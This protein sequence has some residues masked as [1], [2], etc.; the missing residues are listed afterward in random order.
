[1]L[2]YDGKLIEEQNTRFSLA[3]RGLLLGDGVFE[4][5][6]AFNSVPFLMDAHLDRIMGASEQ[7]DIPIERSSLEAAIIELAQVDP[8]PC[9]IRLTATRGVGP[10][11]LVPP[12]TMAPLVFSTRAP[13][14]PGLAFSAM[15]L[16]TTTIR[17]NPTSPTSSLKT[18]AYLDNVM[19]IKEAQE[20][21]ADDALFLS[22]DGSIAC[23]S[24][25]NLF[26]IKGNSLLTPP[27]NGSV[28][29]GIMRQFVIDQAPKLGIEVSE[30]TLYPED[31][32]QADQV[33]ATN[34]VRFLT[35]ITALDGA[36][37]SNHGTEVVKAL[38]EVIAAAVRANNNGFEINRALMAR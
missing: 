25:A 38:I 33:F 19:G 37:L 1:M 4:T 23:T 16:A 3:D 6:P 12:K 18:L 24:M 35:R 5:L 7:L 15:A 36:I 32:L 17:R 29:P 34:S 13:W 14:N 28:L 26:M 31:L 20:K 22:M 9:V 30:N 27:L 11:G 21:G 10:R 2:W 8:A